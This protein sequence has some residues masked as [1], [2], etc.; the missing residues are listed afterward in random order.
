MRQLI[1]YGLVG[2]GSNLTI[3]GVYLIITQ[4]GVEPKIAMTL[5]YILGMT[6]GFIGNRK[7]TFSHHGN[8][9]LTLTRYLFAHL[10]GYLLN[11]SLLF[12]FVD[13]L[14]YPH[15]WI[16][17]MAIVV[18]AGF[19]FIVFKYFVFRKNSVSKKI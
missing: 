3:Y 4:R 15:Q 17:A 12:T 10:L 2:I 19:L 6:M 11:F 8:L 1:R 7:W 9:F 16:Q 5:T 13:Y 14:G 18:V